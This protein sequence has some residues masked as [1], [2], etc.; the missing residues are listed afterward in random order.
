[1]NAAGGSESPASGAQANSAGATESLTPGE[2]LRR[3]R[4]RR[5]MSLQQ[6][7]EDLHLDPRTV[8]AIEEN[9]FAALGVPVYARGHLRKYAALLGLSPEYIIQR[10]EALTDR[11]EVPTP[12][13]ASQGTTSSVVLERRSYKGT[14]WFTTGLIVLAL[15]WWI[16]GLV[17][18]SR[19]SAQPALTVEPPPAVESAVMEPATTTATPPVTAPPAATVP[20][21][22]AAPTQVAAVESAPAASANDVRLRLEYNDSSWTEVYDGAGRRLLFGTGDTGRVRTVAG[23]PPLRVTLGAASA[24]TVQVNDRSVV[25]PRQSG[26]D[27][28]RFQIA[29]NG[30]VQMM[31]G[32]VPVE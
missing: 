28:A 29:A 6:A 16:Y 19:D 17:T 23:M 14:L 30:A 15:G 2:L 9:R 25:V 27:S 18:S 10:Y 31:S 4:D 32:E 20:P 24:V 12:V 26:R 11:P 21:P 5:A 8:Q 22:V 3:E 13:P 7:A 1:M